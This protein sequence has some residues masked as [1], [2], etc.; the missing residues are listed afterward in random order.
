MTYDKCVL[1]LCYANGKCDLSLCLLSIFCHSKI[2]NVQLFENT[3]WNQISAPDKCFFIAILYG[4][5][6]GIEA[7]MRIKRYSQKINLGS[8]RISIVLYLDVPM[9]M[10]DSVMR[11]GIPPPWHKMTSVP[12]TIYCNIWTFSQ[13]EWAWITCLS[14]STSAVA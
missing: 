5:E 3:I 2:G 4:M 14:V 13:F 1:A 7:N 6:W 11:L 9:A 8:T 12:S 10:L